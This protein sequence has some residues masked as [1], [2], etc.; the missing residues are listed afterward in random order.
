MGVSAAALSA[1]CLSRC[2][3]AIDIDAIGVDEEGNRMDAAT[4]KR[5]GMTGCEDALA[6]AA[7]RCVRCNRC[8][9]EQEARGC[10]AVIWGDF[11]KEALGELRG[12]QDL[13]EGIRADTFSCALCGACTL[14]C[15]VGVDA[16]STVRAAREGF[17]RLHPEEAW[18]WQPM[19]VDHAGNAF[20]QLRSQRG[21]TYEDALLGRERCEVLFFPGC[22]LASYAPELASAV[23]ECLRSAGLADG[24]TA[25][26][27]GSP[28]W[29]L[30]LADDLGRYGAKL[31]Q[32]L[33][34]V[35]VQRIV[36][37]CP[38]CLASLQ[39]LRSEGALPADI[40]LEVLPEVLLAA[41]MRIR[42]GARTKVEPQAE[43]FSVHDSCPDRASGRFGRAVRALLPQDS[44]VEMSHAGRD[45]LCCG[46]GG[47]VSFFDG[48]PCITRRATRL[49][50]FDALGV[51]CLVVS[52][53]SCASSLVR[54]E[55]PGRTRHYLE[56]LLD[57][58]INWDDC[59]NAQGAIA[60]AQGC[61]SNSEGCASVFG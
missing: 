53:I 31:G 3:E 44:C 40:K 54:A 2:P 41:G 7:A 58:P 25:L 4:S 55:G 49:G 26:C 19:R 33:C 17:F 22:T 47:M 23:F 39:N 15:P 29:G 20:D 59:W 27:C 14:R 24:M 35:G 56:L 52:C 12:R 37:A 32:R 57:M 28:L 1:S 36:V 30:G 42:Q 18:P 11:A 21:V 60:C 45:T 51:D 43:S 9:S 10:R 5:A 16:P 46:S 38:N 48:D 13:S 50:E 61:P 34:L 6:D 8:V